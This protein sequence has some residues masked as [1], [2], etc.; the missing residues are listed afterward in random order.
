MNTTVHTFHCY[1]ND[2]RQYSTHEL[3]CA[4]NTVDLVNSEYIDCVQQR[5]TSATSGLDTG[6]TVEI[7]PLWVNITL[8]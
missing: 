3:V 6:D 7:L 4:D 2:I 1:R 5:L 8:L